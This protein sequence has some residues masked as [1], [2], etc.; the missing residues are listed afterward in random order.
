MAAL[1]QAFACGLSIYS[2]TSNFDAN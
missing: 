2:S 1:F